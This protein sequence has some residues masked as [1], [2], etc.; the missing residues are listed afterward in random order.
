MKKYLV[1]CVL[2]AIAQLLFIG[3]D[4]SSGEEL[5]RYE[6]EISFLE[7]ENQQLVIV[8]AKNSSYTVITQVALKH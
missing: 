1:F 5:S 4:V 6:K 8:I 7:D 2:L 3:R